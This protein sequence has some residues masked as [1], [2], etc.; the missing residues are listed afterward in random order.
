MNDSARGFHLIRD[1]RDVLVSDYFSRRYSHQLTEEWHSE[2]RGK[3]DSLSFEKGLIF[4]LDQPGY[5]KQ[6]RNWTLPTGGNVIDVRYEDLLADETGEFRKIME[7]LEVPIAK[8]DLDR[9]VAKCS[10]FSKTSR[11]PGTERIHSHRRK[12]VAG[13]WKNHFGRN[14]PLKRRIFTELKPLIERLG[15]P[16]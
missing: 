5:F 13:D 9:I 3:L 4:M 15:Y 11:S 2:L 8:S 1:P 12:A 7:Y 16:L 14:G 6:I 10:F